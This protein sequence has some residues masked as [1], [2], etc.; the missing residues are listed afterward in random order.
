M[1]ICRESAS[2]NLKATT[3]P[4]A[5]HP[6]QFAYTQALLSYLRPSGSCIRKT[7]RA[8]QHETEHKR[9]ADVPRRYAHPGSHRHNHPLLKTA[10][11][12][13]NRI[14]CMSVEQKRF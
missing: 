8:A 13:G 12:Y 7:F 10:D 6:A 3:P 1:K 5:S 2:G 9:T 11:Q 14:P 4:I